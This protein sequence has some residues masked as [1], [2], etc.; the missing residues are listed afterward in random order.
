[1]TRFASID[2]C[3]V[4]PGVRRREF[5]VAVMAAYH[6]KMVGLREAADG[7]LQQAGQLGQT[8]P[9]AE[10]R[11]R[12]GE[13]LAYAQ[14]VIAGSDGALVSDSAADNLQATLG[15]VADSPEQVALEFG[16]WVERLLDQLGRP[17]ST[18]RTSS[19]ARKTPRR[20][21]S[22]PCGRGWGTST[23]SQPM[24][25]R[26]RR[27]VSAKILGSPTRPMLPLGSPPRTMRA[28]AVERSVLPLQIERPA[29]K[30]RSSR[31]RP[32]G[33]IGVWRARPA[34]VF[35]LRAAGAIKPLTGR[36]DD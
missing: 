18:V 19:S 14:L 12:L 9:D 17:S 26:R 36:D 28:S 22:G 4:T 21:S 5:V 11:E 32:F 27:C 15:Q 7:A 33:D 20:R 24:S 23:R 1:M 3:V 8:W 10:S 31:G 30:R 2:P 29:A 16:P 13:V 25:C 6:D 34:P 35:G